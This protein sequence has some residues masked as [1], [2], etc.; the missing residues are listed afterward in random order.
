M[1]WK[2]AAIAG[3]ALAAVFGLAACGSGN[4]VNYPEP[5][6]VKEQTVMGGSLYS[7]EFNEGTNCY[8]IDA[9][10]SGALDCDFS[11]ST[12]TKDGPAGVIEKSGSIELIRTSNGDICAAY[13]DYQASGLDC[14]F[15]APSF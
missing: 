8:V 6:V 3:V 4:D 7:V 13:D 9:Y 1:S 15:H 2:K 14:N 12:S 5:N 10:K 11:E